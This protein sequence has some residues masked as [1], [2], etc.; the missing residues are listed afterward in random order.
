MAP[1][2]AVLAL[3][4][5]AGPRHA[6]VH[7]HA[8][9]NE[10]TAAVPNHQ[11]RP[12]Q[13]PQP[14]ARLPQQRPHIRQTVVTRPPRPVNHCRFNHHAQAALVNLAQQHMWMCMHRHTVYDTA[15][16][17]G[18][19]SPNTRTPT[20]KYWVQGRNRNTTL[21]LTSGKTFHVRYWIPF[22]APM[23]GF[24]DS[25]WQRIPYGSPKY[26][27]SGSHGCIHM[28]LRAIKWFYDWVAHPTAVHI[29]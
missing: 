10:R 27:T 12:A 16:T 6:R 9:S 18:K 11:N 21:T 7:H 17:S 13:L 22:N 23:F 15:I 4:A 1:L 24:H 5:C 14:A 8:P 28:P 26:R 20:G 29:F 25:P 19:T 2:V 3:A